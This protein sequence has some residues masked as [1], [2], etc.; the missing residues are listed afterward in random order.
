[1]ICEFAYNLQ[2]FLCKF[3][4]FFRYA[5]H[6]FNLSFNISY[7]WCRFIILKVANDRLEIFIQSVLNKGKYLLSDT[8]PVFS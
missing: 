4:F 8:C 1:M 3:T 2:S 6:L 7:Y 5:S